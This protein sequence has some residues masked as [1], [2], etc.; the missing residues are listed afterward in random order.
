MV[1]VESIPPHLRG[2]SIFVSGLSYSLIGLVASVCATDLV[3]GHHLPMLFA[4]GMPFSGLAFLMALW[5]KETPTYALLT[6][7]DERRAKK[8][9]TFYHGRSVDIPKTFEEMRHEEELNAKNGNNGAS[10]SQIK[11]LFVKRHL[12]R[13]LLVSISILQVG[14]A[15]IFY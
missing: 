5:L 9:L 12:R 4:L 13:A 3:L 2:T 10:L 8:S 7:R 11:D 15:I 1:V 14:A 6:A